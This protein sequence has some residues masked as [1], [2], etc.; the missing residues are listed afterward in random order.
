MTRLLFFKQP[1]LLLLF[2]IA[3]P[4]AI[5]AQDCPTKPPM[6]SW[7]GDNDDEEQQDRY[8]SPEVNLYTEPPGCESPTDN[9]RGYYNAH[10]APCDF[11]FHSAVTDSST[12]D[13]SGFHQSTICSDDNVIKSNSVVDYVRHWKDECVGDFARCYSVEHDEDIFLEFVCKKRWRFPE[14]TTHV[15]V[16]CKR[17]KEL[18]ALANEKYQS[19]VATEQIFGGFGNTEKLMDKE[20]REREI[21]ILVVLLFFCAMALLCCYSAHRWFAVPY[22]QFLDNRSQYEEESLVSSGN[23][24]SSPNPPLV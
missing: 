24:S 18:K 10:I 17:D 2:A 13:L 22:K 20:I 11:S 3:A 7:M 21:D 19:N 9:T 6:E 16:N 23:S 1:L 14:G 4:I 15:S 5:V 8:W 12:E